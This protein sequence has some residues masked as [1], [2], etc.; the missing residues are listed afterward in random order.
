MDW[1]GCEYVER[2]AGRLGGAPVVKDSRV[3]ADTVLESY[4]MGESVEEIAYSYS[5]K[6]ELI[7]SVLSHAGV[8]G[9]SRPFSHILNAAPDDDERLNDETIQEIEE[10]RRATIR[11]EGVSHDEVL[12]EFGL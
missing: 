9:A 4:Q 8:L 10:S 3:R 1:A 7:V 12:R 5:I 2:V 6:A 11:G